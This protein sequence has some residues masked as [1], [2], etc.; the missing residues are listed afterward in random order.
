MPRHE[1]VKN[2]ADFIGNYPL[3]S[4]FA[5]NI[6]EVNGALRGQATGPPPFGIR[7]ISPDHFS[8][9]EVAAQISF[10]RDSAGK[11]T[12]LVLHQ[13]GMDQR[14][15]RGEL[16]PLPKEVALPTETLR[17]YAGHYPLAPTFVIVI[18]AEGSGLFAQATGQAKAQVFASAKDEFFYKVVPA[19][20]SFQRDDAG[21]VTGLTLHQGGRDIPAQK[22][23]DVQP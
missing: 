11:V 14:G 22:S 7:E 6:T 16:P 12:A 20:I 3:T 4:A 19:R 8:V 13:N 2:A 21:K 15:L 9:M 5:I 18:T 1:P 10:E 23:A 17:D